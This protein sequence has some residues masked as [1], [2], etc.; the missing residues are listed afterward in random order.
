M[1]TIN[2]YFD[3]ALVLFALI[4]K[5]FSVYTVTEQNITFLVPDFGRGNSKNGKSNNKIYRECSEMEKGTAKI[6]S[7]GNC[8]CYMRSQN[9]V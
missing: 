9:K 4:G 6:A 8:F 3:P 7:F 1:Q 2:K 5:L